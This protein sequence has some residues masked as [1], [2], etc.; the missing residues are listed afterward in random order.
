MSSFAL[1]NFSGQ[2]RILTSGG[3]G[4]DDYEDNDDEDYIDEDYVR[5]A[6]QPDGMYA[7]HA[8]TPYNFA[9]CLWLE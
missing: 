6:D 8:I 7:F 4:R 3:F 2:V 5:R 1:S 9:D